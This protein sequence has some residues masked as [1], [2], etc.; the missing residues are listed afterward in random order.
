MKNGLIIEA[1]PKNNTVLDIKPVNEK[2]ISNTPKNNG[3]DNTFTDQLFEVTV[4]AGMPMGLLLTLTYPS[5]AT[6]ISS[7]TS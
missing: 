4:T 1:V 7:K 5:T 2:I 6:Y 3:V